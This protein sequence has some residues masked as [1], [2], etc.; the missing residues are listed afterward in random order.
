ML[1]S[2]RKGFK[3]QP[4]RKHLVRNGFSNI[5]LTQARP[6]IQIRYIKF[7][8]SFLKAVGKVLPQGISALWPSHLVITKKQNKDG[9]VFEVAVKYLDKPEKYILWTTTERPAWLGRDKKQKEKYESQQ[10]APTTALGY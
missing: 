8:D 6:H 3:L 5:V 2:E 7:D 9:D 1:S 4:A 10:D